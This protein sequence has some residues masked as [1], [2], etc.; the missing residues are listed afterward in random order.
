MINVGNSARPG[1]DRALNPEEQAVTLYFVK[2]AIPRCRCRR[3]VRE[4]GQLCRV[5]ALTKPHPD[6]L[7]LLVKTT[8]EEDSRGIANPASSKKR[9][10]V[11]LSKSGPARW[12]PPVAIW[13]NSLCQVK[14]SPFNLIESQSTSPT[15]SLSLASCLVCTSACQLVERQTYNNSV[16]LEGSC[17]RSR[18]IH[19]SFE[20]LRR[21]TEEIDGPSSSPQLSSGSSSGYMM[22]CCSR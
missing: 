17:A 7:E 4:P 22:D 11:V 8:F 14:N 19:G 10:T 12:N 3:E 2:A 20:D 13:K 15:S 1:C 5:F 21:N 6:Q 18:Y 16:D 9:W